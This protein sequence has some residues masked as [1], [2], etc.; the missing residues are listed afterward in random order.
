MDDDSTHPNGALW[1]YRFVAGVAAPLLD[2]RAAPG[3]GE[4]CWAHYPLSDVRARV[5]LERQADL[6]AEASE[7]IAHTEDRL[8]VHFEG[9]WTYGVLPDLE[10][11]FAGAVVDVGRLIFA[12]DGTRLIT[13]RRHALRVIDDVRHEF[14]RGAVLASPID[15]FERLVER[16]LE[17]CEQQLDQV[18]AQLDKIE[19][20]VLSDTGRV[21]QPQLGPARRILSRNHREFQSLRTALSRAITQRGAREHSL[22]ARLVDL[23]QRLE[24]FDRE[25][26]SLQDRARLLHEEVDTQITNATNRNLRILTIISTLMMP[27]T[28]LVGAF[29]MNVKDIP[30]ANDVNG[31]WAASLLCVVGVAGGYVLLRRFGILD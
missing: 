21:V 19:D 25:T 29:G 1:A 5:Y 12:M 10:R 13:A 2:A 3:E 28:I 26:A 24:D 30:F 15:A 16:F 31:F 23:M 27:P 17:V 22:A 20:R 6:P 11:D 8:Q 7:L 9:G 14:E 18:A 4:W